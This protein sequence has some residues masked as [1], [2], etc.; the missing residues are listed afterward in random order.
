MRGWNWLIKNSDWGW[1][2]DGPH[3][4][5]IKKLDKKY[6]DEYGYSDLFKEFDVEW[7]NIT[8]E[9]WSGKTVDSKLVKKAV[10]SKY[11]AVQHP[12]L[13]E[14]MPKKLYKHRDTPF[15]S[16]SKLKH[17][18]TFSMKNMFGM[19]PDPIRAWWHGKDG[20]YHQRSI[21][22]INKI[23]HAFFNM[24]GVSEAFDKTPIWS[25]TGEYG[26]FDYKYY[27]VENLG[28][29]GISSDLVQLDS[30]MYGLGGHNARDSEHIQLAGGILGKYDAS[31][32]ELSHMLADEWV[33]K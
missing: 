8:D 11:P 28:F 18:V 33:K 16:Y 12:R 20:Q 32:A 4:D 22:D 13:Y 17:Y 27:L 3:W 2:R 26:E 29:A 14:Y 31:L 21:L 19:I 10:E 7:V 6:L 23:Y 30:V 1:F 9:I 25:S 15:I 5:Y 24:V